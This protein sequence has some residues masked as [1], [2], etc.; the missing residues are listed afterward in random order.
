[1]TG[2]V[3]R[4]NGRGASSVD[5]KAASQNELVSHKLI[6]YIIELVRIT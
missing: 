3:D 5:S 4:V 6:D 1:M 2:V